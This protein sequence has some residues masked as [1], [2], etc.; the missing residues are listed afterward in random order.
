MRI[1]VHKFT[2]SRLGYLR[3]LGLSEVL[4]IYVGL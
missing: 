2:E 1:V 3:L 4:R